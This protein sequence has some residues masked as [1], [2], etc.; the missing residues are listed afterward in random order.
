MDILII[1]APV[2]MHNTWYCLCCLLG[3]AT[4]MVPPNYVTVSW[5]KSLIK[6]QDS[7]IPRPH[8]Q[9]KERKIL[10]ETLNR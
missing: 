2:I 5:E 3:G 4:G 9:K 6:G 7:L 1:H 8:P 10:Y